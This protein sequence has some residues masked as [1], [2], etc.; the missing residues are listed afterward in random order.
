MSA[1]APTRAAKIK[2]QHRHAKGIERFRHLIHHL[3]VHSPAKQRVRM[4]N[5]RR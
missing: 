5:Q 4:A 3:V 1:A 2:S